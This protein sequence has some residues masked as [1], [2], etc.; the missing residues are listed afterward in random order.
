MSG[1]VWKVARRNDLNFL[2]NGDR[3]CFALYEFSV[4]FRQI[5]KFAKTHCIIYINS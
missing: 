4:I 3:D 5:G 2:H 1:R